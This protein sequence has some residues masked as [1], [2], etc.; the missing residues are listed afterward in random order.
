[1]RFFFGRTVEIN[2]YLD[3]LYQSST[4]KPRRFKIINGKLSRCSGTNQASGTHLDPIDLDD[5][6]YCNTCIYILY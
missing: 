6:Q 3:Q 5:A 2:R 1:M 4:N